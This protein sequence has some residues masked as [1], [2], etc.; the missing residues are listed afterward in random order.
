VIVTL[1]PEDARYIR[2]HFR[3]KRARIV[4]IPVPYEALP[5]IDSERAVAAPAK[6]NDHDRDLLFLGNLYHHPNMEALL[7]FMR[8]CAPHLHPGFTLHLCGLDKPLNGP[9]S[10]RRIY[11]SSDTDLSRTWRNN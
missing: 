11:A 8:E 1:T 10:V 5:L 4:T 7:W 9:R 3:L 2:D 6:E